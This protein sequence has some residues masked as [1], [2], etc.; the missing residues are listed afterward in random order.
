MGQFCLG[1]II[2]LYSQYHRLTRLDRLLRDYFADLLL[3]PEG[4]I[5]NR[6]SED[7]TRPV[8]ENMNQ[9]D[10]PQPLPEADYRAIVRQ[11]NLTSNL[12]RQTP[13]FYL[14]DNHG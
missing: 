2:F 14:E 6:I 7:L 10:I 3:E 4:P 12:Y 5:W 9:F 1:H 13:S 11:I 8:S